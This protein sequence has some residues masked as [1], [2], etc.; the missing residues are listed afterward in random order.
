MRRSP[1]RPARLR[2]DPFNEI[3]TSYTGT[4]TISL[5]TSDGEGSLG[6]TLT[7]NASAGVATFSNLIAGQSTGPF[8]LNVSSPGLAQ[9]V[10]SPVQPDPPALLQFAV[11]NLTVDEDAG[12]ATIQVVRTGGYTGAVSVHLATSDATAVAGVNYSA[13]D[14][15]L[16]FAANQNK[17]TISIPIE[18]DRVVTPDLSLNL[19]LSRP[20]SGAVLRCSMPATLTIHNTGRL[21][22]LVTVSGVRL[23]Y[24]QEAPGHGN[25]PAI[26]WPAESAGRGS[27]GHYR[28]TTAGKGSSFVG[29]RT[30]PIAIK[31]AIYNAVNRTVTLTPKKA[32]TLT[33]KVQLVALASA[34]SGLSDSYG[35]LIDGNRDGTAGGDAIAILTSKAVTITALKAVPLKRGLD[36]A[37]IDLAPPT[38]QS[39]ATIV[40]PRDPRPRYKSNPD[41]LLWNDSAKWM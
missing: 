8:S 3:D 23:T 5:V 9:A 2:R 19:V 1:L 38:G 18:D 20:G 17:V 7:V 41:R 33:K 35:R 6:G 28:L 40:G 12:T 30:K 22:P 10:T 21:P 39:S 27:A 16:E 24:E 11:G 32:A 25:R 34:P 29:K 4:V 14:T 26:Q 36:A 13:V 31:S 37:S 15:T